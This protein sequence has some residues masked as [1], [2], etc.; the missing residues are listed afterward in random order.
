MRVG[1][2]DRSNESHTTQV[3]VN[4]YSSLMGTCANS[5]GMVTVWHAWCS[6]SLILDAC[7]QN[8]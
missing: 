5:V 2:D 4:S 8:C 3:S 1:S 6:G 7:S